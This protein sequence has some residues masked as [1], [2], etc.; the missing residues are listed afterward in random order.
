MSREE[1]VDLLR[2][3]HA[4]WTLLVIN[5]LSEFS[6]DHGPRQYLTPI[7]QYIRGIASSLCTQR[8]NAQSI[9]EALRDEVKFSDGRDIF[10]DENFT[11]S[12]LYHWAVKACD[13]LSES[14]VSSLRFIQRVQDSQKDKLCNE[15]HAQERFEVD[16]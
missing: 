13:E 11:K 14:I 6:S 12:K 8:I 3:P 1:E 16:Y 4:L 5:C 2:T 9:F 15:S 10:D 7:A